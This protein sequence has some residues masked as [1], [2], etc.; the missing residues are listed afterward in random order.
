MNKTNEN[1]MEE[2]VV[3]AGFDG[4]KRIVRF[5]GEYLYVSA[6]GDYLT[7]GFH[8]W[9]LFAV[10]GG[11]Y[12]VRVAYPASEGKVEHMSLS[13]NITAQEVRRRY[14]KLAANAASDG[15]MP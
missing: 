13:R 2:I 6:N 9:T 1:R 4:K 11:K 3:H 15:V 7:P 5:T 8:Q 14:P 12:R 10:P